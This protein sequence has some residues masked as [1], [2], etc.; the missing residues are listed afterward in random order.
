MEI[1]YIITVLMLLVSTVLIKKSD[2]KQNVL[3]SITLTAILFTI[4]N[5]FLAFVFLLI[6]VHFSLLALSIVN[7]LISG[8]LFWRIYRKKETQKYYIK[9]KDVIF[10][11]VLLAV[12]ITFAVHNYKIPF[13]IKYQTTDPAVH[14]ENA[15]NLYNSKTLQWDSNMPSA[16]INTAILFDTFDFM[17]SEN[18]FYSLFIIFDLIILY[19]IGAVFYLGIITKINSIKISIVVM[20]LSI[21]FLFGY[22]LNSVLFGYSYLTVGILYMTTL[23]VM[24]FRIKDKELKFVPLCIEMFLIVFG[25]FFAYFFFVPVI[26][27]SLGIYMLIDM[28][29]NRKEKKIS[30]L[31]NKE[32][33]IKVLVILILPTIM[34]FCYFVLP[35]LLRNDGTALSAITSEG[36]IYRDLY[37][38]FVL[39]APLAIFYVIYNLKNKKNSFSTILMIISSAFTIFLLKKGL[40]SEASSYYYF[41]M[42][43]LL[44][45]IVI[46]MNIKA[47]IIMVKHKNAIYA[48]SFTA[49]IIGIIAIAFTGYDYKISQINILFNPYNSINS[50]A[51]V[52]IFNK[53]KIDEEN[54]ICTKS[55]LDAIKYILNKTDNKKEIKINAKPLQMLWADVVWKITDTEDIRKLQEEEKLNIPEWINDNQKKYLIILDT[56]KDIEKENEKY[57]TIYE[58][59]DA[60]I[61]EK[62]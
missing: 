27:S 12:I 62:I 53:S 50:Y 47:L 2:E 25:I 10:L 24:A 32:N 14:F 34:G 15:K 36:Y 23:I 16:A 43:F 37:S 18:D 48:Y 41:K 5:I 42:Y 7:L 9:I 13:E 39:F 3:L 30:A 57:K 38:N 52:F 1:I 35:G 59:K 40:K 49:F 11:I 8:V 45:T 54:S 51:N 6:K 31:F 22:P 29:K 28:I 17:V 20:I 60:I 56:N 19:L 44:W 26:Y 4:Y 58:V 55:Q 61:L 46:Y 21:I 33:I